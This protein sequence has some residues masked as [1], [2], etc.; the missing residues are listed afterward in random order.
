MAKDTPGKKPAGKP[1]AAKEKPVAEKK[2]KSQGDGVK[3]A[4][5]KGDGPPPQ[6]WNPVL[7]T[8]YT[9][10]ILPALAEKV[11]RK[12]VHDLPRL[13]KITVSMGVGSG[14]TEKKHVEDALEA[15][16]IITGQKAAPTRARKS[17]AS[18][19]LREGLAIGCRVT[20]RGGRMYDFL[21][22]LITVALPRVR[23]FRGL[24]P[25]GFDGRGNYSFG[26]TEQL[27]F[28]E[29]NPDKFTRPQ[30]MNIAFTI[31]GS[32]SDDESRELLEMFGLPLK[33][34]E[35]AKAKGA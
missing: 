23:D 17:I 27:V 22:R 24:N 25:N 21:Y 7:R 16:T 10:S 26:L 12:N 4:R 34:K 2:E 1:S 28:P 32:Q 15:M 5:G 20:L 9:E 6:K 30:G 29:L 33:T 31:S 18:F 13:Q 8:R 19:K 11:G 14:I 3:A 35:A